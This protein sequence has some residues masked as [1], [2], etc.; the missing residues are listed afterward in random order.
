[1]GNPIGWTDDLTRAWRHCA[2]LLALRAPFRK[3]WARRLERQVAAR[4]APAGFDDAEIERRIARQTLED[5]SSVGQAF[6]WRRQYALTLWIV[7]VVGMLPMAVIVDTTNWPFM[8]PMNQ[9]DVLPAVS[10]QSRSL[11]PS[12]L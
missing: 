10:R 1:M 2:D 4:A 7:H 6:N 8:S 5:F 11:R 3:R 9:M 12:P